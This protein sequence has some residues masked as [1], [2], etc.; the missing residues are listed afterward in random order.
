[1]SKLVGGISHYLPESL[2]Y[3]LMKKSIVKGKRRT[4]KLLPSANANNFSYSGNRII[5]FNLPSVGFLDTHNTTLIFDGI[6]LNGD[7]TSYFNNFIESTINRVQIMLGDGSETVELLQDYNIGAC[8]KYKFMPTINY[9]TVLQQQAGYSNDVNQRIQWA[10]N[11]QTYSVNMINCGIMQSAM[12]YL[13]LSIMAKMGGF[14]RAMQMQITLE[15]PLNCMLSQSGSSPLNYSWSNVYLQMELLEFPEYEDQLIN[16]ISSGSMVLGIPYVSSDTWKNTITTN[17]VGDQTFQINE[18]KEYV[19]GMRNIFIGQNGPTVDYTNNFIQPLGLTDYQMILANQY[20]PT[21]PA[22]FNTNFLKNTA[23]QFNEL[24]KYFNKTKDYVNGVLANYDSTTSSQIF[25]SGYFNTGSPQSFTTTTTAFPYFY[26]LILPTT[27]NNSPNPWLTVG[28][29]MIPQVSGYYLVG[30]NGNIK[31]YQSGASVTNVSYGFEFLN[32]NTSGPVPNLDSLLYAPT[33]T[34]GTGPTAPT[35]N[36]NQASFSDVVFLTAGVPYSVGIVLSGATYSGG[37]SLTLSTTNGNFYAS[38]IQPA[39][40]PTQTT[41]F[42]I[43]QTF[44]IFYDCLSYM[45]DK[46]TFL[47][48]VDTTQNNQIV[49]RMTTNQTQSQPLN[50]ISYVDYIGCIAIDKNGVSVI[51]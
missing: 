22:E 50:L 7:G 38:L 21:Q 31:A 20:Y 27:L 32:D 4:V 11:G 6:Q 12:Q 25:T 19:T 3:R 17:V 51:R 45:Y 42:M 30:F 13:P 49:F 46:E 47:D 26:P 23:V 5:E 2:D 37:A 44:R 41:S 33:L 48:G 9:S 39:S 8:S 16:K 35:V 40:V 24:L 10:N 18:Y 34:T 14:S 43:A 36:S 28:T 29:N 15:N 1:M